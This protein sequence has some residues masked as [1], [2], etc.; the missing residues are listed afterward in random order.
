MML[1]AR[2]DR[3]DPNHTIH[4]L[5]ALDE[6]LCL[7]RI[8]RS[9]MRLRHGLAG[10][11]LLS[12]TALAELADALPAASVECL[13]AKLNVVSPGY[14]PPSL[15]RPSDTVL[16]IENNGRWMVMKNI[17]QVAAYKR[18]LN[19][20]LDQVVPLLPRREGKIVLTE[21]FLFLSA[22]ESVTP[23]HID[24][25]HN[26]LMQVTGS[27][28]VNVGSL[29]NRESEQN[30]IT[31]YLAGGHR[32]LDTTPDGLKC[33]QLEAGDAL[34]MP[35]WRPHWVKNGPHYS[36][37]ISATFRTQRSQRYEYTH[38]VNIKLRKLGIRPRP[39]GESLWLD[40]I[41]A[42]YVISKRWLKNTLYS[43]IGK[44]H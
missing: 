16:N 31:R 8:G 21:A 13:P 35:P 44:R 23:V 18:L 39:A 2:C 29:P 17:E 1:S 14:N 42:S 11:H 6:P 7:A 15:Q 40:T 36:I 5:L 19:D 10:H 20:V 33:H 38:M 28:Q 4:D 26:I 22:P 3:S 32:N 24:P 34:Y 25:E 30:E 27:K 9:P 12:L 37:S 43:L 41:K